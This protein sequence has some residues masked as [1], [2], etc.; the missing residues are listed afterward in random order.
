[1]KGTME[2]RTFILVGLALFSS[3]ASAGP[4]SGVG[5]GKKDEPKKEDR[6]DPPEWA[7]QKR[8]GAICLREGHITKGQPEKVSP[9]YPVRNAPLGC[10]RYLHSVQCARCGSDVTVRVSYS[11]Q[12]PSD[13]PTDPNKC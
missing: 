4:F 7:E 6:P 10:V 13:L 11:P 3:L 1:V 12:C 5:K 9:G 2:R 8:K